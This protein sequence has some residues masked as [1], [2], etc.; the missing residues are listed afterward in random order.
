M[1]KIKDIKSTFAVTKDLYYLDNDGLYKRITKTRNTGGNLELWLEGLEEPYL[2][3]GQDITKYNFAELDSDTEGIN[4]EITY[5]CDLCSNPTVVFQDKEQAIHHRDRCLFNP[6][7]KKCVMCA[8]LKIIEYPPYPRF[9]KK[10]LS[11]ETYHAFGAYKQPYC[12]KKEQNIDE[13][14][15]FDN[16]DDCFDFSFEPPFL[17]ETPEF[18]KY[19]ELINSDDISMK[20][21]TIEELEEMAKEQE[22]E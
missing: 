17:E 2:I 4:T 8:N 1:L 22:E 21:V 9:E 18:I 10:Y 14:L 12:M 15:L 11:L 13:Y 7:A 19:I 6:K 3:E 5:S 16:H 20:E